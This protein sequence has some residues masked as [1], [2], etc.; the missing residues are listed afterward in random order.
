MQRTL[1]KLLLT[2]AMLGLVGSILGCVSSNPR[3]VLIPPIVTTPEG[4]SDLIRL[5]PDV[6]GH[7]YVF[8]ADGFVLSADPVTLP[9]G[10]LAAPPPSRE[11]SR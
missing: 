11:V 6:R 7:I 1:N 9:E 8:T 10:W 5:G 2:C 3:V 4:V